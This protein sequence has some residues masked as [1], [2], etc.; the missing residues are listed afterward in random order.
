MS[1]SWP[2]GTLLVDGRPAAPVELAVTRRSRSKGLLGRDRVEGAVW[3]EPCR[4][5]HTF[6]MR[7]TID[8]AY[9]DRRGRVLLVRTLPP[10]RV[11][12]LSLRTR[13]IVEAAEGAFESWGVRPGATLTVG[14]SEVDR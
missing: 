13:S 9:V 6:R 7:F 12:P 3:F 2:T 1:A 4:Q 11:A 10:G 5:I 8:V 14:R